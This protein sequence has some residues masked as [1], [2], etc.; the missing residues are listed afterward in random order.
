[1]RGGFNLFQYGPNPIIWTD[2]WGLAGSITTATHITYQGMKDGK[3]YVGYASMQGCHD[4]D[5][6]L[7][8]RYGGNFGVFDN[9]VQSTV[10]YSG[11]GQ[12]G[13]DT[14]RGLE[15][16][17]FKDFGGLDKTANK[18]NPVETK[19]N[20]AAIT[21]QRPKITVRAENRQNR[22]IASRSF[23]GENMRALWKHK[24]VIS[25]KLRDNLYSLAQMVNSV[26][27]MRF[28]NIFRE[29]DKW[30]GV[31]LNHIDPLFCVSVG[32][33]V[34]QRLGVRSIPPSEV[35]PSIAPCERLFIQVGDNAEGYRLRNE[36]FWKSGN[37]VDL[38]EDGR[39]SGWC[40]PVII[41]DLNLQKHRE[42][43]LKHELTN[44]Y[45]EDVRDRILE[46]YDYGVNINKLKFEIFPGL[47]L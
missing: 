47:S 42:I 38:G 7:K 25:L 34:M 15:H 17:K 32:N 11:Y 20:D 43:I 8:Y 21:S 37:L 16:E 22:V 19:I 4:P 10:I 41:S 27:K 30:D 12:K 26:A 24:K 46:Y 13:K 6:V 28:Y 18:Q 33:V 35:L 5:A 29:E 2:P 40:A 36:F 44:M 39:G 3:P 1:M 9:G 45:G 14:A 23:F 31:D